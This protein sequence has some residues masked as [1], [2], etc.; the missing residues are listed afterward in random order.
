MVLFDF[1]NVYFIYIYIYIL[2]CVVFILPLV[3]NL[4]LFEDRRP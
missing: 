3:A 1:V 2:A 4:S